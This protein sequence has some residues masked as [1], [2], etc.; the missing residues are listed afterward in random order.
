M[1][2]KKV[3]E[4]LEQFCLIDAEEFFNL[5]MISGLK[6][7]LQGSSK[8]RTAQVVLGMCRL[9]WRREGVGEGLALTMSLFVMS[10]EVA[11]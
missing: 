10:I 2:R 7:D 4:D 11:V 6:L 3:S 1:E 5:K 8:N 9:E